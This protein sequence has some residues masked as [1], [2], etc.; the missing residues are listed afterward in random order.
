[1]NFALHIGENT[2]EWNIKWHFPVFNIWFFTVFMQEDK[3]CVAFDCHFYT[4]FDFWLHEYKYDYK[5]IT[6]ICK[7]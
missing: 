2:K 5:I 7:W 6:N 3:L 1:M 4:F